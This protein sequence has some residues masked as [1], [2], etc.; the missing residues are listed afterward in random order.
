MLAGPAARI[1][2]GDEVAE[3][4]RRAI[5]NSELSPGQHLPEGQISKWLDV[6]RSPVRAALLILEQEGLVTLSRYRGAAVAQLTLNDFHEVYGLRSAIEELAV[7]LA[8]QRR[9]ESDLRALQQSLT[10]LRTGM[11][12]TITDQVAAQ[13]DV[14]FHDDIYRAAH[15]ERLYRNWS[16]VRMQVHWFLLLG[17][18]ASQDWREGMVQS[19]SRILQLIKAG[20]K[21]GAVSAVSEHISHGYQ[22]ICD[23]L[24]DQQ[25][26]PETVPDVWQRAE[27]YLFR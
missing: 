6:S 22:R 12:R 3:R 13:L 9:D 1:S 17:T 18:V 16:G 25:A 7:R 2:L 27:S 8:I 11:K 4:L 15:H 20:D 10:K 19:H 23:A 24:I 5:L 26:G 21:G 14:S